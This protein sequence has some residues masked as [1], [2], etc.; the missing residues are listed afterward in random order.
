MCSGACVLKQQNDGSL[1]LYSDM[2]DLPGYKR[3]ALKVA[4]RPTACCP[5]NRGST[6][7]INS[8]PIHDSSILAKFLI[9][10]NTTCQSPELSEAARRTGFKVS[11]MRATEVHWHHLDFLKQRQRSL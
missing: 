8:F 9:V 1:T 2:Y 3:L 6:A 7:Q 4:H 11:F 5:V 10:S